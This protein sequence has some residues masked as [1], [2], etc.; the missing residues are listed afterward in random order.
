M[1][2]ASIRPE[3]WDALM[4]LRNRQF[5]AAPQTMAIAAPVENLQITG[6]EAAGALAAPESDPDEHLKVLANDPAFVKLADELATLKGMDIEKDAAK[7]AGI[8]MATARTRPDLKSLI[9]YMQKQI[10]DAKKHK[11]ASLTTE[12]PASPAAAEPQPGGLY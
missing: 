12:A 10:K 8:R 6:S 1:F 3:D 11:Q 5:V 9:E 2:K 4:N 7:I